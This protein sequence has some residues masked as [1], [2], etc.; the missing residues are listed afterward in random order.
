[1]PWAIWTSG[2]ARGSRWSPQPSSATI[3]ELREH[4]QCLLEKLKKQGE[5]T[6]P[7]LAPQVREEQDKALA[8]AWARYVEWSAIARTLFTRGDLLA[9]L[10]LRK[11]KRAAKDAGAPGKDTAPVK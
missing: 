8:A 6:I 1:M 5:A 7:A 3:P 10:G 2:R 4:A 9:R 11:A